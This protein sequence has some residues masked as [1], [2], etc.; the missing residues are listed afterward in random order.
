VARRIQLP[1]EPVRRR[2]A[3]LV[4]RGLC[5][6]GPQGLTLADAALVSPGRRDLLRDNAV[7]VQRMYA[8]LAERGVVAVW[9]RMA[10]AA[11]ARS[12]GSGLTQDLASSS[13]Y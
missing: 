13:G 11:G 10:E 4:E 1:A 12:K 9:E 5:E 6:S 2:A 3:E 8:G 7:A